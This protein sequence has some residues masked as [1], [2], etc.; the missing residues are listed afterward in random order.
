VTQ[1]RAGACG[2]QRIEEERVLAQELGRDGGVDA[3]VEPVQRAGAQRAVD[4]LS[5]N[6][7]RQELRSADDSALLGRERVTNQ[8]ANVTALS[9]PSRR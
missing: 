8:H 4:R 7:A 5:L 2:E 3:A 9:L 6:A 1:E